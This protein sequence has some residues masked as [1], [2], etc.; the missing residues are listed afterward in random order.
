[1][2]YP[3]DH[4]QGF[5]FSLKGSHDLHRACPEQLHVL[6]IQ[7]GEVVVLIFRTVTCTHCERQNRTSKLTY[8]HEKSL[9]GDLVRHVDVFPKLLELPGGPIN[10]HA[11]PIRMSG[12][13]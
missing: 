1:M 9:S 2:W 3:E 13:F 8:L 4:A 7:G 5:I 12:R 10:E 6:V 11:S